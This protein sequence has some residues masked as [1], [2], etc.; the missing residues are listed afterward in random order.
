MRPVYLADLLD[1]V[2]TLAAM[3]RV[4]KDVP[5]DYRDETVFERHAME[6]AQN[7]VNILERDLCEKGVLV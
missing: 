2:Q 6:S 7:I 4:M 1:R 5:L 3:L